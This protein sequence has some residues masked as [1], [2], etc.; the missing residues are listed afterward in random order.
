MN[1]GMLA[2]AGAAG[3]VAAGVIVAMMLVQKAFQRMAASVE[4]SRRLYAESLAS[5]GL[6]L[7]FVAQRRSLAK[8]MGVNERDVYHYSAAGQLASRMAYASSVSAA[9]GLENTGV[10]WSKGVRD[11][12]MGAL[13]QSLMANIA[14]EV[15]IWNNAISGMARAM[16]EFSEQYRKSWFRK[17]HFGLA[18][19][20]AGKMGFETGPAQPPGAFAM[21][22]QASSWERMGM[23][24]GGG[25]PDQR[26]AQN[27]AM[28]ASNTKQMAQSL[29]ALI[30]S[31]GIPGMVEMSGRSIV[32]SI[33]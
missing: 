28:I 31:G 30:R 27:T 23:V 25:S 21:R 4:D 14:P 22:Y 2:R 5:G 11:V 20:V 26:I 32:H 9:T 10:A 17:L 12:N 15:R 18:E 16:T 33:P 1:V 7:G 3:A 29:F 6:P 19:Y 13:R 24:V 8:V